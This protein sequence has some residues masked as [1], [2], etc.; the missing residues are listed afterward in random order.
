[1]SIHRTVTDANSLI[2]C[3]NKPNIIMLL[4]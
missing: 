4:H 1:M 3:I 2:I